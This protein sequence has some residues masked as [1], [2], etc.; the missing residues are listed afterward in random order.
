MTHR[1]PREAY[2]DT[3]WFAHE[4]RT[5]FQ[6]AWVAAATIHD[7]KQ[8]GDYRTVSCGKSRIAV[9]RDGHGTLRAFH[10]MC[11][12]RGAEI[13]DGNRGNC[14]GAMVCPYHRWTYG[15]DGSL[16]G[17][18]SRSECFPGL[19][20]SELG[21]KPAALGIF[22]DLVFV[23][24][25]PNANFDDWITP[26]LGKEWPHDIAAPDVRESAPL[27]YDMKCNWKIYVENILDGY[28][29]A[30][31]HERTLGGP[32]A[33]LNAWERAGEHMLWY[34]T[35]GET[36]HRLP[37][38]FRTKASRVGVIKSAATPCYPGVCYLFPAT[39]LLITPHGLSLSTLQPVAP[40]R[41]RMHSRQWV[42]PWQSTDLRRFVPGYDKKTN[43][44]SSDR[45]KKHP[46]DTGDFQT[47]DVWACE[48]VQ[49]GM[50]SPAY[51]HGPL[52]RGAG[53]EDGIRVFHGMLA[54]TTADPA[55]A[56]E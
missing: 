33:T 46:L 13:L 40:D 50:E 16:R 27:V 29:F 52:S 11:R 41:C 8:K 21:L 36:R 10:D 51:E 28:H 30:H 6:N 44:V 18:P 43:T 31:L 9:V 2:T 37:L 14:G 23:N 39:V 19:R 56:A 22:K 3:A 38:R 54:R 1:P 53:A 48:K 20:Q 17:V 35:E 7:F 47:E 4:Q 25:N 24:P 15:L 34:S 45:W 55:E 49:R 26:L 12:H 32:H 5:L 42:G